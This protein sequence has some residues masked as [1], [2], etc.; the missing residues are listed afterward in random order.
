MSSSSQEPQQTQDLVDEDFISKI[1]PEET[2]KKRK[3]GDSSK[4]KEVKE[5]RK[6][7][8]RRKIDRTKPGWVFVGFKP[9]TITKIE[10]EM[11]KAQ[12]TEELISSM[13]GLIQN[14]ANHIIVTGERIKVAPT[15]EERAEE[16]R[17]YRHDYLQQD[18]VREKRKEK[19]QSDEE[20]KKR[21]EYQRQPAVQARKRALAKAKRK[22]AKEIKD[23][24]PE[25]YRKAEEKV[26][27]N[28]SL[29]L[30]SLKGR[31]SRW[32]PKEAWTS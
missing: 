23:K 32:T 26:S 8:K 7:S 24:Y 27:Q 1:E 13:M 12:N 9:D 11:I 21:T 30:P 18:Y 31:K 15:E 17:A 28:L 25:I 20:K 14:G 2:S 6:R 29:P 16:K 5:G 19:N 4:T 10:D 22:L 3:R